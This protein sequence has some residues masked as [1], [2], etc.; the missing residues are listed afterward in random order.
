MRALVTGGAGLVGYESAR[1]FAEKGWQ[2]STIDNYMRGELFGSEG[3]TKSN[4]KELTREYGIEHHE[5]DIRAE[6]VISLI[7]KADA[8]VHAAAQPSHPK[9]IEIPMEDFQINAYGTLF[10]LDNIRKYKKDATFVF[11]STNKVYGDM[12]NY[13]SYRKVRKRFEPLDPLLQDGFDETLRLDSCMHTPFG[14]SKLSG[15]LYTQ[16]YN[17]L[18]GLT[19]GVFRMGCI[20][21]GAAKAVELHNWEPFF[22]K[23]ALKD[24]E[25]VIYGY[26]GYQVRDVI[27]AR[28]LA[29]LFYEFVNK[30]HPGEVY[31]VGGGRANSISLLEAIELI[32]KVTGKRLRHSYGQE[33]AGDHIWWISNMRKVKQH[34]PAWKLRNGLEAI[35]TEIYENLRRTVER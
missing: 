32:E 9:S 18:Y 10:L 27:H 25:L 5:I 30:P 13:F 8:V 7:K 17:K 26:E 4:M 33:R 6:K 3:N 2:V 31:N 22:V 14:V 11:C 28:D 24:E 23:K 34:Y 15:D 19:T 20:T 35:F 21:G 1:L 29:S 16:D 12:P